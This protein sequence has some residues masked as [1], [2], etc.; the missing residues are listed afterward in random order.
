LGSN[1]NRKDNDS[2]KYNIPY[3]LLESFDLHLKVATYAKWG[4]EAWY[5]AHAQL[6]KKFGQYMVG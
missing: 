5:D 6:D 3:N 1:Y 4:S 2:H